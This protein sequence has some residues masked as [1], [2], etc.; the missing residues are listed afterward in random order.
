M[1]KLE[2]KKIWW[3]QAGNGSALPTLL[4]RWEK[5]NKRKLILWRD[6]RT[7]KI[8]LC[9][10]RSLCSRQFALFT[11]NTAT[12]APVVSQ[13]S[14]RALSHKL[15]IERHKEKIQ[16]MRKT[17]RARNREKLN[18]YDRKFY[19]QHAEEIRAQKRDYQRRK[20]AEGT[21]TNEKLISQ[22][23]ENSEQIKVRNLN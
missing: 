22:L 12:I 17:Y 2:L 4:A 3:Q 1:V 5:I 9:Q 8:M 19:Q 14:N 23:R 13:R 21:G 20:R 18:D 10:Q 11:Y 6:E 15:Y 7:G 16:A